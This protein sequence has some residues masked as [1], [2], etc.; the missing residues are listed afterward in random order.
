MPH[1]MDFNNAN[2]FPLEDD[3]EDE[4]ASTVHEDDSDF[5][6]EKCDDHPVV[7]SPIHST[8]PCVSQFFCAYSICPRNISVS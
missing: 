1:Q 6:G 2:S 5:D 4:A 7:L 3:S 8:S